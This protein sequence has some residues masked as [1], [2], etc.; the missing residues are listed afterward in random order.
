[1]PEIGPFQVGSYLLYDTNLE[2]FTVE[3][4]YNITDEHIQND[5]IK[6]R[7]TD[8]SQDLETKPMDDNANVLKTYYE[9]GIGRLLFS[10]IRTVEPTNVN[11]NKT[12]YGW[13]DLHRAGS[14]KTS[15]RGLPQDSRNSTIPMSHATNVRDTAGNKKDDIVSDFWIF[16]I[17][18]KA[19]C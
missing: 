16:W 10:T 9:G 3:P 14:Q 2:I 12:K 15:C 18:A 7:I 6:N 5:I 11:P 4:H 13:Q 1:M 8:A 17:A 19:E